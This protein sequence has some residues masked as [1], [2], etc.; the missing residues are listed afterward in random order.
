MNTT[1]TQ[2]KLSFGTTQQRVGL[3]FADLDIPQGAT[4]ESAYIAMTAGAHSAGVVALTLNAQA[5]DHAATFST[6]RRDISSRALTRAQASWRP[7]AWR[8]GDIRR[9]GDLSAL[10]QEVVDRP[11]WQGGN[12]LAFVI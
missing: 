6:A 9:T 7:L 5:A 11:G 3:R 1:S 10:V 4:I 8:K 12:A 2:L